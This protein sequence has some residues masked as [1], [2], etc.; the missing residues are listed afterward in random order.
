MNTKLR[1]EAKNSFEKYF[2]KLMNN[3][4]FGKTMEN[5]RKDRNITLV[6]TDEK[7]NQLA[8]E[9]NYHTTKYFS[10]NLMAIEM[11]KTK[12]KT[13]KPIYLGMSILDIIKTLMYWFWYDYI[14]IKYQDRA[15][16]CYM[17]TDSFAIHSK[18]EDFYKDIANDVE[19]WFDIS[20]CDEN[21]KRPHSIGKNEKVIGLFKGEL[22][23]K[24]LK[25]FVALRAKTYVY[26]MNYNSEYKKA[27]GTRACVIK[28]RLMFKNYTDCLFNDKIIL[29]SQQRFKSD[30]HNVWIQMINFDDYAKENKTEHNLKWPYILDHPY[31]ILIIGS[32]GSG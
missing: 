32:S 9:L 14:K 16:L 2:F 24:I 23:G 6:T 19:K 18:T 11:K 5:V 15:K 22:G 10:E 30:Y 13:N 7:R 4:V 25:K 28:T 29:K 12:V 21:D 17:D 31:R 27:K 3:S 8:S 20:N 26:L 1:T